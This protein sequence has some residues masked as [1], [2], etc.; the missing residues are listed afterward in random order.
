MRTHERID[1]RSLALAAAIVARIDG[2]P[3]RRGLTKARSV[4]RRW[5]RLRDD[6]NAREWLEILSRPWEEIRGILL[7]ESEEGR[8][9]R[10][11]SP[12]CGI[13]TPRERWAIYRR[14][15]DHD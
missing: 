7:D 9:L 11:S 14:F 6:R 4:C 12:F 10:Q 8:R 1:A 13:L 3:E 15:R 2:D 5:R